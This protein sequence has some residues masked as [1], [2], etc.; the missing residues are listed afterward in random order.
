[1]III[2]LNR[3]LNLKWFINVSSF[4]LLKLSFWNEK[5]EKHSYSKFSW[6]LSVN[7]YNLVNFFP[8]PFFI[9][10][11]VFIFKTTIDFMLTNLVDAFLNYKYISKIFEN[12][13]LILCIITTIFNM[14]LIF[15]NYLKFCYC[16]NFGFVKVAGYNCITSIF[17]F[18]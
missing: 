6:V 10:I 11:L 8:S 13:I 9:N 2:T 7:K 12:D 5:I 1:M 18:T 17:Y 16:T 4:I 14:F 15:Y 3:F